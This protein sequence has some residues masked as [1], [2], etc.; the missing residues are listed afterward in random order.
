[1]KGKLLLFTGPMHSKKTLKLIQHAL[2]HSTRKNVRQLILSPTNDT[3]YEGGMIKSKR[4]DSLPA[5]KIDPDL[6]LFDFSSLE[7]ITHLYID[8]LQFFK[9]LFEFIERVRNMSIHVIGAGLDTDFL[10]NIWLEMA[11]FLEDTFKEN[12][13][14]VSICYLKS[15]CTLCHKPNSAEF[16]ARKVSAPIL[17]SGGSLIDPG[18]DQYFPT[19][20]ICWTLP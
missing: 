19:C 11:P 10:K 2:K 1:M 17:S 13:P 3:R 7:G 15:N 8:E 6:S 5:T 18:D 4:G 12:D 14:K 9:H 20:N 16:T